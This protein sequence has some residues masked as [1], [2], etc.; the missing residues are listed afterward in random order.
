M[1]SI[2]DHR[3]VQPAEAYS[4]VVPREGRSGKEIER[5]AMVFQLVVA[6]RRVG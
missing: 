2:E 5:L 4:F 6:V 3:R 1:R